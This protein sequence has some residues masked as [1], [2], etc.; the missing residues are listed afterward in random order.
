V[1]LEAPDAQH[2]AA[3]P[4]GALAR[5][6]G[7]ARRTHRSGHARAR[8]SLPGR[9]WGLVAEK[10]ALARRGNRLV[11]E[12]GELLEFAERNRNALFSRA[13]LA[14]VILEKLP[15]VAKNDAFKFFDRDGDNVAFSVFE[16]S[17]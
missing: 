11:D 13:T 5:M 3:R 6:L 1:R 10:A 16:K 12:P 4:N 7:M 17:S 9:S 15:N 14:G 8:R 2:L